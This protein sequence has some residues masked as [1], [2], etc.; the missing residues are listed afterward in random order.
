MHLPLPL[1]ACLP[2]AV[3]RTEVVD[4]RSGAHL[5]HVFNDGP[6]PTGNTLL[7]LLLPLLLPHIA[8]LPGQRQN[9]AEVAP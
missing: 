5:G 8:Q 1:P 4:A 7:P 9:R 6:R 3:P 2:V